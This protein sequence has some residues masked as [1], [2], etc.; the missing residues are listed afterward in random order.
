[1]IFPARQGNGGGFTDQGVDALDRFVSQF[2]GNVRFQFVQ[3]CRPFRGRSSWQLS[4]G[5]EQGG[6]V[7]LKFGH[8]SASEL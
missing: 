5:D 1:M 4:M 7:S 8:V 6:G 3:L 2:K